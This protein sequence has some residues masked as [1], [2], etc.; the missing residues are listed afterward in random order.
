VF[1]SIPFFRILASTDC[2]LESRA[3]RWCAGCRSPAHKPSALKP[4][5]VVRSARRDAVV[6]PKSGYPAPG[7]VVWSRIIAEDHVSLDDGALRS[8]D[9]ALT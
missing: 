5:I 8:A 3:K 1:H 2:H 4:K 7:L 6:Y 9:A